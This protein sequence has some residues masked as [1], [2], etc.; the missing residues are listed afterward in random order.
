MKRQCQRLRLW[1][2]IIS[3]ARN[4]S[5]LQT[6]FVSRQNYLFQ[7]FGMFG[8]MAD[9]STLWRCITPLGL[10]LGLIFIVSS[11]FLN[12]L[13]KLRSGSTWQHCTHTQCPFKCKVTSMKERSLGLFDAILS[14]MQSHF[15]QLKQRIKRTVQSL[16]RLVEV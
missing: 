11:I 9:S 6:C 1:L 12:T 5:K 10:N 8:N 14:L 7:V 4:H 16:G 15:L 2:F 3:E 13:T